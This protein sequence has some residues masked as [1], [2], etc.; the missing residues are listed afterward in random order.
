MTSAIQSNDSNV[1]I[2]G[3]N[4]A[5]CTNSQ[6][7]LAFYCQE[8]QDSGKFSV[9]AS[10]F[11]C[12]SGTASLHFESSL[13]NSNNGN[14]SLFDC[15]VE[16]MR[17]YTDADAIDWDAGAIDWDSVDS[18]MLTVIEGLFLRISSGEHKQ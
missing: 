13:T 1:T 7:L 16:G 17:N 12:T 11:T 3:L 10:G 8:H 14:I 15:T 5:N 4:S 2:S 18:S 9:Q 6:W